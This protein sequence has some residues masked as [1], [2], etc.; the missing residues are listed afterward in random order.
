VIQ[1]QLLLGDAL[2]DEGIALVLD[3]SPDAWKS[4]YL[5]LAEGY[6]RGLSV[7]SKFIGEDLRLL[8]VLRGL[9][10]PHHHNAWGAMGRIVI[11]RWTKAGCLKV[12]GIRK[13]QDPTAHSRWYPLYEKVSP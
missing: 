12:T 3:H 1:Q 6:F 13:S 4:T 7:G 11:G 9:W 5:E 10:A 8:L 2:R